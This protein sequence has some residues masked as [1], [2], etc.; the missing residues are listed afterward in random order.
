METKT[1]WTMDEVLDLFARYID[2]VGNY[3]GVTFLYENEW[4]P[5]EWKLL[6]RLDSGDLSVFT[7]DVGRIRTVVGTTDRRG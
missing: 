4:A 2:N 5:E 7:R 1:D 6:K 3:E